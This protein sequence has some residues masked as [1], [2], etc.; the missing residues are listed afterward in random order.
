MKRV[1]FD[2]MIVARSLLELQ[3]N[4]HSFVTVGTFDGLHR[5]HQHIIT[6][7]R[8]RAD[9][10]KAR[11]VV[12][13]FD[14]HP[15]EVVGRGP[16]KL[17]TTVEERI[18]LFRQTQVDLLV[19][20]HFTFEFSRQTSREFYQRYIVDGIGA[21]EVVVGHDHM[22]GRDREAGVQELEDLGKEFVFNVH[23]VSPFTIDGEIVSSSKIRELLLRGDVLKAGQWLGRPY[24]LAGSI[25]RGD[26]RGASLGYPT[27]NV[28]L[29]DERKLVPAEG[30]YFVEVEYNGRK[31]YGMMNIGFNPTFK[32]DGNRTLEVYIFDF[33]DAI[34]GKRLGISLLRR[35][36]G[37]KKFSNAEQLV[38]QMRKDEEQCMKFIEL[39]EQL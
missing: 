7:L 15:R 12:V 39:Q 29:F 1:S 33:N 10:K 5:G 37:E 13:T 22:F 4:P 17:L 34:Y 38:E 26:G 20:L 30:V 14:P 6:A 11:S 3:H 19:I 16:V 31:L 24:S 27:A 21:E 25:V 32:K 9:V 18:D 8:E 2:H 35:L 23:E 28:Q 36:R